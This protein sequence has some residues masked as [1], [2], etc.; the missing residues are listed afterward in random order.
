MSMSPGAG[1]QPGTARHSSHARGTFGTAAVYRRDRAVHTLRNMP[2][3][4]R[5]EYPNAIHH[6]AMRGNRRLPVF[7]LRNDFEVYVSL[8]SQVAA[9]QRWRV[10]SYC[11]MS[12]HLHLLVQTPVPNLSE[13]MRLLS[14][15]YTRMYNDARGV[16]GHVFQGRFKN[17][18]V[19][20]DEHLRTAFAYIAFNP[21]KPGLC[22]DPADWEWSA[23]RELAGMAPVGSPR[24]V[25]A[26]AL[27]SFAE[28][29]EAARERY[30]RFVRSYAEMLTVG[31]K[32]ES[33]YREPL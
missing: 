29:P 11:L 10:L 27:D 8:L 5:V 33:V 23:H 19:Q 3:P 14:G 6:V 17:Q 13:G 1:L 2:R 30:V 12:N 24:I 18:L 25:A 21:V 9:R 7:E 32:I 26:D 15:T 20:S 28:E 31:N 4:P 22:G 16:P